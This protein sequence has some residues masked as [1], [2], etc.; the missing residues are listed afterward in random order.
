MMRAQA[1]DR[2]VEFAMILRDAQSDGVLVLRA[3]ARAA[4]R[5]TWHRHRAGHRHFLTCEGLR[6]AGASFVRSISSRPAPVRA[7]PSVG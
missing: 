6:T 5:M 4:E 7:S 1:F 2:V 3:T